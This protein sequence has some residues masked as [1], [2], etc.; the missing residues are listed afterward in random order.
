ML[1][2]RDITG[3]GTCSDV[4]NIR[5]SEGKYIAVADILGQVSTVT[6]SAIRKRKDWA[7]TKVKYR[8]KQVLIHGRKMYG[9]PM[10]VAND[11]ILFVMLSRPAPTR[12]KRPPRVKVIIDVESEDEF[13]KVVKGIKRM[14]LW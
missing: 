7:F 9:I 6:W 2:L 13:D 8:I 4:K 12:R 11:F 14:K 5:Q 3:H 10:N 1:S